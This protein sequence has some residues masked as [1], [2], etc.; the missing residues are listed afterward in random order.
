MRSARFR[1]RYFAPECVP[2]FL[3]ASCFLFISAFS[4]NAQSTLRDYPTA[5]T[6]ND[7]S[8]T[9]APRPI[10]D[11]RVTTY[12]YYFNGEQ[13]D[14]FINVVTENLVGDIDVFSFDGS[15]LLTRVVVLAEAE[16]SETGRVVYL[17][18]PEKLLIRIQGRATND[19]PAKFR[20]KFAGSFLAVNE[21]EAAPVPELP[22]VPKPVIEEKTTEIAR[23]AEAVP[24][25][26][27]LKTEPEKAAV[28]N[29]EVKSTK[30]EVIITDPKAVVAEE[31]DPAEAT[32]LPEPARSTARNQ[33]RT[34]NAT[35]DPEKAPA[36]RDAEKEPAA[37]EADPM[38]NFDLVVV[39]KDGSK[40][41]RPMTD[42][43]RFTV[44]KGILTVIG[45]DGRIGRYSMKDI[46]RVGIE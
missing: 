35:P 44:D 9:I 17:R 37:K 34:R 7:L 23:A 10:G 33:R 19:E 20:L 45:K 42:V 28:A 26:Q 22:S 30:P 2:G 32:R 18:K 4:A 41:E 46:E 38:A 39:F 8:G 29:A 43:L 12:Y 3:L 40:I 27:E 13:G 6:S 15:R 31:K 24:A 1:I 11:S 21:A 14:I 36:T 16:A 5:I 25:K